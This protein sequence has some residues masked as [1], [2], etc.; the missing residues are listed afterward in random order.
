V[1]VVVTVYLGAL[2]SLL[3]DFGFVFGGAGLGLVGTCG[4]ARSMTI[5]EAS[6]LGTSSFGGASS[7]GGGSCFGG[8]DEPTSTTV[9]FVVG[10]G[11]TDFA[12]VSFDSLRGEDN[13]EN[14]S[15]LLL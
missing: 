10:C 4:F 13:G 14:T 2:S 1:D 6:C 8:D 12:P 5:F 3:G 15:S 7:F 11:S 9:Q